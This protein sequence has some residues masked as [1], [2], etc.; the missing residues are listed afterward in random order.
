MPVP[1]ISALPT[2]PS[3]LDEPGAF[4]ARADEFLGALSPFGMQANDLATWMDTTA[5][6]VSSDKSL[7][8]S[9][10]EAVGT[11]A[12]QVAEN[13]ALVAEVL[14][15]MGRFYATRSS[16]VAATSVGELFTSNEGGTL[17]VYQRTATTPFYSTIS[18]VGY[19]GGIGSSLLTMASARLLGRTTGSTGPIEEL[20]AAGLLSLSGGTLRGLHAA[21]GLFG[22]GVTGEYVSPQ[23]NNAAPTT[24]TLTTGGIH[25]TPLRVMRDLAFDRLEVEVTSNPAAGTTIHLAIYPDNGGVPDG[26]TAL[27]RTASPIDAVGIA[28]KNTGSEVAGALAKGQTYWLAISVSATTVLRA[29]AVGAMPIIGYPS[30]SFTGCSWLSSTFTHAQLPSTCLT[31]ALGTAGGLT[32]LVRARIA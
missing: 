22:K 16:G 7:V 23:I 28:I 14:A 32:P 2:A 15:A 20:S 21:H 25:Y 19:A 8:L 9:T 10:A 5:A 11:I 30:S 17:A 31:T 29:A 6:A 4:V 27:A 12:G 18:V 26:S 24:V 1:E 3:R 13:A